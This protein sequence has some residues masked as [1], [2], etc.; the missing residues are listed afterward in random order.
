MYEDG[1]AFLSTSETCLEATDKALRS[2]VES[3]E[4]SSSRTGKVNS[5]P[6][7]GVHAAHTVGDGESYRKIYVVYNAQIQLP[8]SILEKIAQHAPQ[9][10]NLRV[11]LSAIGNT[12]KNAVRMSAVRI[13]RS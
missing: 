7:E 6:K 3:S 11:H 5:H 12:S 1:S 8:S 10:V 4:C 9:V 13:R 2:A